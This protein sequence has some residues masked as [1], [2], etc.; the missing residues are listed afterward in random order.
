MGLP[1]RGQGA[2]SS[3]KSTENGTA[4]GLRNRQGLRS[5]NPGPLVEVASKPQIIGPAQ[6]IQ[7]YALGGG[8]TKP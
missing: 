1:G 6:F 8:A 3:L 5:G 7:P 4:M 2:W